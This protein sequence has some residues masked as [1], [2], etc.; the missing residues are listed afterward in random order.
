MPYLEFLFISY[1][2][3]KNCQQDALRNVQ[4]VYERKYGRIEEIS[5]KLCHSCVVTLLIHIISYVILYHIMYTYHT[6]T[7]LEIF[8]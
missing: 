4:E 1:P 3:R 7:Y 8:W 2:L 6:Y 5:R